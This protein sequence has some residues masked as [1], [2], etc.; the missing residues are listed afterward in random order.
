[1][2]NMSRGDLRPPRPDQHYQPPPG[3]QPV[4][5]QRAI[6]RARQVIIF[7]T[8]P[9]SGLFVYS[10]TP[11]LGT[12]VASITADGTTTDPFGNTVLAGITGYH[13]VTSSFF[14]ALQI[15]RG[16]IIFYDSA[17]QPGPW[18]ALYTIN[19]APSFAIQDSASSNTISMTQSGVAGPA[20]I[21][22]G[23]S[24]LSGSATING[25]ALATAL[26]ITAGALQIGLSVVG[27]IHSDGLFTTG[28]TADQLVINGNQNNHNIVA[29]AN[30]LSNGGQTLIQL[31]TAAGTS[32]TDRALGIQA[33]GDT[34]QRIRLDTLPAIRFGPGNAPTDTTVWRGAAGQVG[35]DYIAYSNNGNTVETWQTIGFLN[36]WA[37]DVTA[38]GL[39]FR[40]VSAP[41]NSV[42][43]VGRIVAPV[44]I[45]AN[46]AVT[47][48]PS[49]PYKPTNAQT[50]I[51]WNHTSNVA[52][53]FN[54]VAGGSLHFQSGAIAGDI[55]EIP[56]GNGLIGLDA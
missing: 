32:A 30:A 16:E 15:V 5:G 35:S 3:G 51:G 27:G 18:T 6:V 36:G 28:G 33:S 4:P 7:G 42:Q 37:N 45:V 22:N 49:A 41:Y 24:Q 38:P 19:A 54:I 47:S 43:W 31:T 11:G 48:S 50:I 20:L 23:E 34:G 39:Q 55:L 13:Q 9:N 40:R 46:Q 12:L 26:A 1:M 17:A 56:S 29:I 25:D 10:P 52:M 2:A 53:Q 44:G 21:V 8:G 14:T